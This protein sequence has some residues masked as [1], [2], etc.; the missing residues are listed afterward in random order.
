MDTSL[1]NEK[2]M[3][4]KNIRSEI[5]F[6]DGSQWSWLYRC[7]F[8]KCLLILNFCFLLFRLQYSRNVVTGEHYRFVS[9]WW[10]ARGSY[11]AAFF[12]MILFVSIKLRFQFFFS[13][14]V[15]VYNNKHVFHLITL[16]TISQIKL[17]NRSLFES[18]LILIYFPDGIHFNFIALFTSSNFCV[19]R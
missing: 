10:M 6:T 9:M 2:K 14:R 7:L 18:H 11:P 16:S 17:F 12:I 4:K 19:H 1:K 5:A 15:C 13:L 3:K 8:V